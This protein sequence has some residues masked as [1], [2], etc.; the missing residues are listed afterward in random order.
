MVDKASEAVIMTTPP[1]GRLHFCRPPQ[2]PL[3]ATNWLLL[4]KEVEA[5][6]RVSHLLTLSPPLFISSSPVAGGS[7]RFRLAFVIS[8]V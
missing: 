5:I 2:S 3:W 7:F 8:R 4:M 6:A 1:A